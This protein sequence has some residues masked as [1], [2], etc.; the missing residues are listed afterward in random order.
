MHKIG[1]M[2]FGRAGKA[3]ANVIL[4]HPDFSLDFVIRKGLK[5][6]YYSVRDFIGVETDDPA[7]I[8]S[9]EHIDIDTFL[10]DHHVDFI[11]DFYE[12]K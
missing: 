5:Q 6:E 10:D 7:L 4:Q 2:G 11:I 8:Y 9:M 1:L 12:F 3:V